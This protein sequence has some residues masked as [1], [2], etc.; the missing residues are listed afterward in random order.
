M[1]LARLARSGPTALSTAELE[2]WFAAS[3]TTPISDA[4]PGVVGWQPLLGPVRLIHVPQQA[5]LGAC[6]VMVLAIGL[7]LFVPQLP[8]VAFVMIAVVLGV[9]LSIVGTLSPELL[10]AIIYGCEPGIL[11][12]VLVFVAQWML[13]QRYRRQVV[14]MPAFTRLKSGSSLIRPGAGQPRE[15]STVDEPSQRSGTFAAPN[16]FLFLTGKTPSTA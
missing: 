8:R 5:W 11:V 7:T 13:H 6:S 10:S 16:A 2:Q 9:S 12:C 1:G 3:G 15:P 14:F 4:D